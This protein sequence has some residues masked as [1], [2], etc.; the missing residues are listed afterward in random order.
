MYFGD[1]LKTLNKMSNFIH[2]TLKS[3]NSR[4]LLNTHNILYIEKYKGADI[5][6]GTK[7][8]LVN[9]ESIELNQKIDDFISYLNL[10][11]SPLR[12]DG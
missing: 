4:I 12:K 2:V 7:V 9:G 11:S 5:Y 1:S 3:S 6:E 10:P 8:Y